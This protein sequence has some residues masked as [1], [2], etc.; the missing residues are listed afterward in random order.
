MNGDLSTAAILYPD[1][2]RKFVTDTLNREHTSHVVGYSHRPTINGYN[3]FDLKSVFQ[4]SIR[5]GLNTAL[6]WA[7][8]LALGQQFTSLWNLLRVISSEDIGFGDPAVSHQI[9]SLFKAWEETQNEDLIIYAVL[10]SMRAKKSRL[11]DDVCGVVTRERTLNEF[12]NRPISI[13]ELEDIEE[14]AKRPIAI[15]KEQTIAAT[16]TAIIKKD[17]ET[18]LL[19]AIQLDKCGYGKDLWKCIFN[20]SNPVTVSHLQTLYTNYQAMLHGDGKHRIF[21]AHA[22]MFLIRIDKHIDV[23]F[24][25]PAIGEAKRIYES[26][27][28]KIELVPGGK[29]D[30]AF[31]M[32]TAWGA[33]HARGEKTIAGVRFFYEV[34]A[35]LENAAD[36]PNPYAERAKALAIRIIEQSAPKISAA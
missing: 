30:F 22:V 11:I 13:A 33:T 17:E 5:R 12:E 28:E 6:Y 25:A 19:P 7:K 8:E 21:L 3:I 10:I 32:H 31:D 20:L 2:T 1:K 14:F 18:A 23:H 29:F 16:R 34:G 36:I 27:D 9:Y 15:N 35:H 24:E 26:H 4:K